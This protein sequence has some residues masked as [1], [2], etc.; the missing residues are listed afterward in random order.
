[1]MASRV[2]RASHS[3]MLG[4]GREQMR[5][6]RTGLHH[7]PAPPQPL[8]ISCLWDVRTTALP[9]L[10]MPMIVFHSMRRAWGSM[11]V[12]GSSCGEAEGRGQRARLGASLPRFLHTPWLHLPLSERC[13]SLADSA[14]SRS[15]VGKSRGRQHRA[16]KA[17][18]ESGV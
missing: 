13:C 14:Q 3:S 16:W 7:P 2:H 6:E 11:P 4:A 1:M 18:G 15:P 10:M 17:G 5:A 9:S 8:G 12:V